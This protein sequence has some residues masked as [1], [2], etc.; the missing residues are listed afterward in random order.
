MSSNSKYRRDERD[1]NKYRSEAI[2]DR[3]VTLRK[4]TEY[5]STTNNRY[6]SLYQF[7]DTVEKDDDILGSS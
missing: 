3:T 2:E 6:N 1:V 4:P 7:L 5:E